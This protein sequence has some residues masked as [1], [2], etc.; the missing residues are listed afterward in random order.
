MRVAIRSLI[1]PI[2]CSP[3]GLIRN[4]ATMFRNFRPI[5]FH[6]YKRSPM[7]PLGASFG[8]EPIG[9]ATTSPMSYST[10]LQINSSATPRVSS[11]TPLV[12]NMIMPRWSSHTVGSNPVIKNW[13]NV[14]ENETQQIKWKNG[15]HTKIYNALGYDRAFYV[16]G[17]KHGAFQRYGR[18]DEKLM[19][20]EYSNGE[21]DGLWTEW[22]PYT[23]IKK[24]K[25]ETPYINGKIHGQVVKWYSN[26]KIAEQINYINGEKHGLYQE[27]HYNGSKREEGLFVNGKRHKLWRMWRSDGYISMEIIYVNGEI[28]GTLLNYDLYNILFYKA[29][30]ANG[31][32]NGLYQEYHKN[33]AIKKKI[34]YV[35]GMIHGLYSE[36]RKNGALL[37]TYLYENDMIKQVI[38]IRDL[39]GNQCVLASGEITVWKACKAH[40]TNVYVRLTVPEGARRVTPKLGEQYKSRVEYAKV[41]QIIDKDGKE[42]KEAV[43]YIYRESTLTYKV[44]ETVHP[45]EFDG[46]ITNNCG[47]GINVHRYKDHCDIWFS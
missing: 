40:G 36:F 39:L 16:D 47:A 27:F 30:Y 3:T 35:D 7:M 25:S 29:E 8:A 34:M 17:I 18:R 19:E 6:P 31:E 37:Y 41:E 23:D 24:K 10:I 44:G 12:N 14:V 5:S 32:R 1:K 21:K 22:W 28:H 26:G 42:Y 4:P 33:G 15:W 38:D 46:G 45:D 9:S 20:G 11:L 2:T 13:P 43:S